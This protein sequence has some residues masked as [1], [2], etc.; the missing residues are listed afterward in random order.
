MNA[1]SLML[2]ALG[3]AFGSV[4]R[5]ALQSWALSW[6][7]SRLPWGTWGVNV[8][9]SFLA[10]FLLVWLGSR[11]LPDAAWRPLLLVGVLGGF[12][13]FSGFSLESVELLQA[14]HYSAA[15]SYVT[16]SV[17]GCL[18]ATAAGMMLAR[19]CC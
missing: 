15:L 6:H 1:Q 19:S 5:Y 8:L 14:G 3:G 17:L 2:V 7:A 12:T 11:Y 10:G 4:C 16:A 9:G 18:I 13:T